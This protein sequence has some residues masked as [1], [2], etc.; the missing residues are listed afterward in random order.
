[1]STG[2]FSVLD[3]STIIPSLTNRKNFDKKKLD[4]L[5]A[6]IQSSGVHQPILVR[7]LPGSRVAETTDSGVRPSHEIVCG[8]RRY[9]ASLQA[10]LTTIP[11]MIRSLTDSE[12]LEIQLIENLQRDDLT[13]LE[14]AE[15]YDRLMLEAKINADAVADK[16]GKSRSYVYGRLKLLNLC[17]EA[18]VSL[19][20]GSIDASCALLVARIPDHK[21]QIKA[22]GEITEGQS[23]D[24]ESGY[25]KEPLS[26]RQA[27]AIIQRNYMLKL[28]TAKFRIEDNTLLPGAG[29]CK[30][31][32]KR[33][34]ADP[35]LLAEVKSADVCI[36]PPCF[37]AK[38]DA[39]SA[40]VIAQAQEKGQT[41]IAADEAQEL[42]TSN[43]YTDKLKGYKRL[44]VVDDSP[45]DAPLRKIIGKQ[46]QAEGIKAVM[47]EHPR[48]PGE[49][50]AALPNDVVGKLLKTVEGQAQAAKAVSKEAVV[51][52]E[53]KKAKADD[54]AHARY[55]QAWRDQLLATTWQTMQAGD[56]NGFSTDVYRYLA[57]SEAAGYSTENAEAVAKLLGLGK[58][59]AGTAIR[60]YVKDTDRPDLFLLLLLMQRESGATQS[61]YSGGEWL[62]NHGMMLVVNAIFGDKTKKLIKDIQAECRT[63]HLPTPNPKPSTSATQHSEENSAPPPAARQTQRGSPPHG[64]SS[65]PRAAPAQAP[66]MSAEEATQGIAAAMQ[67]L[68]GAA[69]APEGAV[70][71]PIWPNPAPAEASAPAA[72]EVDNLFDRA[73][74]LITERQQATRRLLKSELSIGTATAEDL[75]QELQAAGKVSS[76]DARGKRTVLVTA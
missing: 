65:K 63:Q 39:H 3:L 17:S 15:G 67:G 43:S 27:A 36:D 44:D 76:C 61:S 22:M 73:V 69:S 24:T 55:E 45:T 38:S 66:K 53:E 64:K 29:S 16:I 56:T 18:R 32:P 35:D 8:E 5:A 12:A 59:G 10:C 1:M 7:P 23:Y 2:E 46:M 57:N 37:K 30:T 31:C 47:I 75:M 40:R 4:E 26:Y 49:L 60:D 74:K 42:L 62:A 68:P 13:A 25:Q 6:S 9:R 19:R 58:V 48:K 14:E 71:Q 72:N 20:D 70:A 51:F 50:I 34:G 11:A 33:T 28:D 52:A 41:V 21:L 54:K